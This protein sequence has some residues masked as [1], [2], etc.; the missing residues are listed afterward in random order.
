MALLFSFNCFLVS[1]KQGS[2]W[3]ISCLINGTV[4]PLFINLMQD[5]DGIHI[6]TMVKI[7]SKK[8]IFSIDKLTSEMY[9]VFEQEGRKKEHQRSQSDR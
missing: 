8:C 2:G 5:T 4:R 1:T 6:L 7:F 3:H 9:I